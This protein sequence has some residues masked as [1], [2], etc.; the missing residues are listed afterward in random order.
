MRGVLIDLRTHLRDALKRQKDEISYNLAALQ[1]LRQQH[2]AN[3]V[4]HFYEQE[5]MDETKVR[6]RL[7]EGGKKR[8]RI[9]VKA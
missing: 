2:E 4:A 1:Y 6:A 7:A 5:D 3:R 9:S 8:K